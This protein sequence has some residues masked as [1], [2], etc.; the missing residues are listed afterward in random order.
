MVRASKVDATQKRPGASDRNTIQPFTDEEFLEASKRA[1]S[2]GVKLAAWAAGVNEQTLLDIYKNDDSTVADEPLH[3]WENDEA[4]KLQE[5]R[6]NE[7][8][9]FPDVMKNVQQDLQD[10]DLA[11]EEVEVGADTFDHVRADLRETPGADELFE[12]FQAQDAA[13]PFRQE[14]KAKAAVGG[15][16]HWDETLA[17]VFQTCQG[18]SEDLLWD[19]LWRLCMFLRHWQG[20]SDRHWIKNPFSCRKAA[21]GMSWYQCLDTTEW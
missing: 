2:A 17:E 10:M 18:R 20:G 12:V 13:S 9:S 5:A 19:R 7:D 21:S 16:S 14:T 6:L 4:E 15:G 11:D 8:S 3:D 1:L